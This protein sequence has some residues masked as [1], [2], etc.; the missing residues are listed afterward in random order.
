[1][2]ASDNCFVIFGVKG[3]EFN[4]KCLPDALETDSFF[5]FAIIV[6]SF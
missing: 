1:M 6:T 3:F 4:E 5:V 2:E